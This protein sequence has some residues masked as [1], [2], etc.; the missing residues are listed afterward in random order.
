MHDTFKVIDKRTIM[1][2]KG[3]EL[4]VELSDKFVQAIKRQFDISDDQQVEDDHIRMY[5]YGAVKGA[6]DK[7]TK[8]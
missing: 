2:P 8:S 1:L 3:G 7:E 4:E 6:I 5:I